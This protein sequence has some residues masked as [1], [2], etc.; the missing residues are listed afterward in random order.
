MGKSSRLAGERERERQKKLI[1]AISKIVKGGDWRLD[2]K[3]S[4]GG[5]NLPIRGHIPS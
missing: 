1:A 4:L 5:S 3:R 2:R